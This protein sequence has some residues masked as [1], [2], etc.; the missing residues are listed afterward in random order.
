MGIQQRA[1][2]PRYTYGDYRQWAGDERFELIEGVPHAMAP[3]PGRRHQEVLLEVARQLG[4]ALHGQPCRV[5]IAPFD[6]RLPQGDES[7]DL[8]E[9]VVQP[10]LCVVCDPAKLDAAGCRGAPDWVLEVLSPASA[11]RDQIVKRALYERHGVREYWLLHPLDR[12]LTIYRLEQ[13]R[14]TMPEV[15]E[16]EGQTELRLLP[17][18]RIDWDLLAAGC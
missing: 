18:V 11:G 7:D 1:A 16:L 3:A 13:G 17:G 4:N 9:T 12:V 14:Y 6:V 2:T 10:D 8:V 5:Y 15:L